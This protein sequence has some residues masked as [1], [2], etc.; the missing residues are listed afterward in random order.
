MRPWNH[1]CGI[2]REAIYQMETILVITRVLENK[3]TALGLRSD[4]R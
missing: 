4:C 1:S 3:K 2:K